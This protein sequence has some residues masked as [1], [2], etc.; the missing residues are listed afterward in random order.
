[1]KKYKVTF[2]FFNLFSDSSSEVVKLQTLFKGLTAAAAGSTWYASNA[3]NALY[4][5]IA[6]YVIDL[7]ISCLYFEVKTPKPN[8][9][10]KPQG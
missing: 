1:M 6:G 10:T 5:G 8:E 3:N 7:L 2:S 9:T 4:I